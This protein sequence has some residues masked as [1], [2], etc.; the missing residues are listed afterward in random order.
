MKTTEAMYDIPT[1]ESLIAS[2]VYDNAEYFKAEM[3]VHLFTD[4]R[5]L[6]FGAIKEAIKEGATADMVEVSA[7]LKGQIDMSSIMYVFDS[8][9]SVNITQSVER[10]EKCHRLRVMFTAYGKALE[11]C[12][13][14]AEPSSILS[15]MQSETA[16]TG[17]SK[18]K[19][20]LD[21]THKVMGEVEDLAGNGITTGMSSGIM[22][23]DKI[24]GGF[25]GNEFVIIAARPG[26]GKTSLAMNIARNMGFANEP[27]LIFSL[28]MTGEQLIKRM[29]CDIGH[30]DA[31]MLFQNEI[32]FKKNKGIH[33]DI[34]NTLETIST[35]PI[36]IDDN[37]QVTMDQIYARSKK[38]KAVRGIKWVV[39]DYLG[40]IS[41]WNKD[42]QGPKAEITRQMKVLAK[43]I[44][45]TVIV[46]SQMN[47]AI[48]DRAVKSPK[49]SDLRDAGSIE[50]DCDIAMFPQFFE[51]EGHIPGDPLPALIHVVKNRKGKTGIVKDI[52]WDGKYFRYYD[53]Q[54]TTI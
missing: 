53:N 39:I 23:L 40:L 7:R 13:E 20:V 51:P 52:S 42:G 35:F 10:L 5:E 3:P 45:A 4:S 54:T 28:E 44:D 1:E 24:T 18:A 27:G 34:R 36:E 43:D 48:E 22:A 29:V 50:Q 25:L 8:P 16:F 33:D 21:L 49:M 19:T 32:A 2:I 38:A 47:R 26:D 11:M 15:M 9:V 30:V 41:G 31:V 46:L 12:K 6:I 14:G 37:A 17:G